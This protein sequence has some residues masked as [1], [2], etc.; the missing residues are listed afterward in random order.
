MSSSLRSCDAERL[1]RTLVT[2]LLV[3]IQSAFFPT[4]AWAQADED[5]SAEWVL[6]DV[7]ANGWTVGD[8]I[9][10]RLKATY[11]AGMPVTLPELPD[12]W[13]AFEVREQRLL[14]PLNNE[15][16]TLSIVREATVTLWAPGDHQTPPLTV[17]YR[18]GDQQL[19]EVLVPSVSVTIASVLKEDDVEKRDLKPQVTL[20]RPPLWPWILAGL[21]V[22]M[23]V[24]L[25]AWLLMAR[26][27]RRA[28][29]IQAQLQP[30][31]PRPPHA[32]A[33]GEL[34]RIASLNL[35][36]QGEVKYRYTLL[37]DCMRT[38]V[39]GRYRIPAMDHTTEELVSAFRSIRTDH[40]HSRMF[41]ELLS[42][43][44]LVKFAKLRPSDDQA[45]ATLARARHIV[46]ATKPK[47]LQEDSETLQR[48][49]S[50]KPI[51]KHE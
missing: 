40:T 27:R 23:L 45:D 42:E 41:G 16:G 3:A 35:P 18:D 25:V 1:G 43:A 50:S 24:G 7:P 47:D 34:T 26:W 19:H 29:P 9:P 28:I 44:D 36:S 22:A 46:D 30:V 5:V 12:T 13:G 49:A 4:R 38:Y 14:Q 15:N 6:G 33:Y 37:A 10:L 21:L 48:A 32:I 39:E 2:L 20:P 8:R 51:M 11:P 31:D 17:H